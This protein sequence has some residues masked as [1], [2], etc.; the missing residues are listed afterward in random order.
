MPFPDHREKIEAFAAVGSLKTQYFLAYAVMGSLL[1][2]LSV[3]LK[4]TQGLTETQIGYALGAAS[5]SVLF[6]PVIMT[7]LADIRFDPR[8]LA[9]LVFGASGSALFVLLF[10][11]GFWP[12]LLL[13]C[14]H[15]FAYSSLIPLHDGM[16]FSI[17]RQREAGGFPSVPYYHVRVWG[18]VGFIFPSLILFGFLNTGMSTKIILA[19][20]VAFSMLSIV[21][22]FRLPDPRQADEDPGGALPTTLAAKKLFQK[23][24]RVFC[25]AM[26]LL[27]MASAGYISFYPLYMVEVVGVGPQWVGLIFNLGVGIEIGFILTFGK[28]QHRFGIRR[29]I[30]AGM[31]GLALQLLL[32]AAFP[33]P[34]TAIAAQMIHGVVI[35]A[36]FVAPIMYINQIAGDRFRN[37]IQGLYSMAILGVP[38]IIGIMLAGHV[39]QI[40][41]RL[42]F[43]GAATLA[44]A[45]FLLITLGFHD[46]PNDE[47]D[48]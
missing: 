22:S 15:S 5:V 46:D 21:N 4:Q 32:L 38:R 41:L 48:R 13:L 42:V 35:L 6:T 34:A 44:S 31:A 47:I 9:A 12:T 36:L 25:V 20:S 27:Y 19:S 26:F 7:L 8:T 10:A 18:S 39:A 16:T 33:H 17:K 29:L 24:V 28:L 3:Y 43:L 2:Y 37:S 45:A 14:L 11:S 30:M 40:D 23:N 1:P